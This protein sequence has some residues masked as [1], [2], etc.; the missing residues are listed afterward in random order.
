VSGTDRPSP[1]SAEPTAPDPDRRADGGPLGRAARWLDETQGRIPALSFPVAV[2]KKFGE[3]DAGHLAALIAYFGFFS[4]FPLMLA[5]TTILGFVLGNDPELRRSIT[6]S[7]LQ[8]FPVI[9]DDLRAESLSGSWLALIVG[10]VGA[11]WAGL[12]VVN[13]TQK[14]MNTVWDVP[15]VER[16]NLLARTLRSLLMLGVAAGFLVLSG[17][18]SGV[19]QAVAGGSVLQV[20]SLVGS[21][22]VNLLLFAAAFRI[23][24]TADVSWRDVL[25]GAAAAAVAWTL[26][27]LVGQWFVRTRIEGAR[28]AYGTFAVVIG[29]LSWL[30]LA[31]Q[32]TL[33]AA[34]INV[35]RKRRLWPRS[36]VDPASRRARRGALNVRERGPAGR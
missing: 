29:L 4:I 8:Q 33:F 16:P 1:G 6:D 2:V 36:L 19:A 11:T 21:I 9:G 30:Y 28:G 23:L 14:A 3:D 25:P 5:L 15:I 35:V 27:L 10:L 34:E 22:L 12:G 26:L 17:F 31:S 18:L 32:V 7:A 20:A 13:A 24:T